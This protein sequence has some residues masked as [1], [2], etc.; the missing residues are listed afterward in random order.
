VGPVL[1]LEDP[2]SISLESVK[3]FQNLWET[4]DQLYVIEYKIM[5]ATDPDEEPE[6]TFFVGLLD[7]SSILQATKQ[8]PYYDHYFLAIY[9]DSAASLVW[10]STCTVMVAGS[11]SYF[12][13]LEADVTKAS[14]A[15]NPALNWISGVEDDSRDYLGDWCVSL[16]GTLETS[17]DT[18]LLTDAD[19]L[20][21]EGASIFKDE[22]PGLDSICVGIFQT[23][24]QQMEVDD[25]PFDDTYQTTLESNM[26]TRLASTMTNLGEA[27]GVSQGTVGAICVVILFFI[28]AG[29]MFVA[30][31]HSGTAVALSIPFILIGVLLNLI[32]V[33]WLFVAGLLIVI[34]FGVYFILARLA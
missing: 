5:Y 1:A 20:N 17:W 4:G 21:T 8:V 32:T 13:E 6:D 22:I 23:S 27:I 3:V 25:V 2:D 19:K 28:I 14:M 12:S 7:S 31:G 34:L 29:R 15:L 10:E 11:P 33:Q 26:G 30:T 18:P 16:A 24:L 9:L